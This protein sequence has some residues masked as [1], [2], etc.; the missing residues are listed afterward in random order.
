MRLRGEIRADRPLVVVAIEEEAAYLGD[1]LPALLTGVGKVNAAVAVSAALATARPAEVINVGTAGS[2][3]SGYE[4][5]HEVS[6]VI[7]HDLD[8]ELLQALTGRSFAAPIE[9]S[10]DG[11]TLA[12]GDV[13][14]SSTA[15]R[16][17]IGTVADLV[18]M[19]GYAVAVAAR[20]AGVPVRL[21]KHVS[22]TADDGAAHSWK[23]SVDDA[24]RR[25]A[26]WLADNC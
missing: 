13:F 8:D 9:L 5:T 26:E 19:E 2:V 3:R 24:A 23:D 11:P 15:D 22:D 1:R 21:V 16:D 6:R 10:G 12:T 18:D 7:Q 17:R 20:R 14:V 25:L 4:G